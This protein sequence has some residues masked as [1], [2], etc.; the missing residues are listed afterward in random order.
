MD[1]LHIQLGG[2]STYGTLIA[3]CFHPDFHPSTI[4]STSTWG[5]RDARAGRG[6]GGGV[7]H[8]Y[9]KGRELNA[10]HVP[11]SQ[12]PACSHRFEWVL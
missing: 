6:G 3:E 5:I 11:S 1:H 2:V 12:N 10:L 9:I 7:D 8:V 4:H